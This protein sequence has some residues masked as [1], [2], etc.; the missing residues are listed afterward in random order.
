VH[1]V[2]SEN[3]SSGI[4]AYRWHWQLKGKD[5][6]PNNKHALGHNYDRSSHHLNLTFQRYFLIST[7]LYPS[8]ERLY[9][10]I[11]EN[12]NGKISAALTKNNVSK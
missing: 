6:V 9:N 8:L 11:N 3:I 1:E 5:T 10:V 2:L 12:P 4:T 7:S